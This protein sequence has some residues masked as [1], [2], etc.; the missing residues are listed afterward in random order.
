MTPS[1]KLSGIMD[2][3]ESG[4]TVFISTHTHTTKVNLKALNKWRK[5]GYELFK[6]SSKSLY[7]ASGR[8]FVCIDYCRITVQ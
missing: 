6:A 5:A 7:M 1:E 4:R 3:L 2:A 8:K